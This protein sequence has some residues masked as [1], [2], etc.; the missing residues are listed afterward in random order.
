MYNDTSYDFFYPFYKHRLYRSHQVTPK[1]YN[2]KLNIWVSELAIYPLGSI[3]ASHLM[4]KKALEFL[5]RSIKISELYCSVCS[6]LYRV[7]L[8]LVAMQDFKNIL[9]QTLIYF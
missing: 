3:G 2:G 6:A 9:R 5:F 4:F 1:Q 8:S 7:L